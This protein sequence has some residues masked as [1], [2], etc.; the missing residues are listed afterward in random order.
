MFVDLL[1]EGP[2]DEMALSRVLKVCGLDKGVTF[3]RGGISKVRHMAPGLALRAAGSRTPLL[4][5][6]DLL[7]A[8]EDCVALVPDQIAPHRT[9][10]T[11]VRVAVRELESW[12]LCDLEGVKSFFG[13]AGRRIPVE[14]ESL[15][16]P[17]RSFFQ[18]ALRSSRRAVRRGMVLDR[19]GVL[20]PGPDY[21]DLMSDFIGQ[22]WEPE[23]AKN[24]SQSLQRCMSRLEAMRHGH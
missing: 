4:V 11:L 19:S 10:H 17:K 14:P 7:G 5:L 2:T 6:V 12:L 21:L 22:H 1:V 23:R 18:L 24:C 8:E 3:G 13:T 20:V 9:P 16:D 15:P